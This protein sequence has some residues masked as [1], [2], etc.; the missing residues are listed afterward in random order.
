MTG[1]GNSPSSASRGSLFGADCDIDILHTAVAAGQAATTQEK[2]Q[3]QG[4]ELAIKVQPVWTV[5]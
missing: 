2:L 4:G 3:Q 1:S 5:K